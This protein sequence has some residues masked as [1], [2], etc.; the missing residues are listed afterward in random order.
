MS[1]S[2][3]ATFNLASLSNF[4]SRLVWVWSSFSV[5]MAA[6]LPKVEPSNSDFDVRFKT[7]IHGLVNIPQTVGP[8]A[9]SSKV[10]FQQHVHVFRALAI[11]LIVCTHVVPSLDWSG[12]PVLGRFIDALANQSSI[13]FFFIA[14]YLFQHLSGKFQYKTYLLQKL[15]TVILPYLILSTPALYIFT[16]LV[17]REGVWPWFY[18]LPRWKQIILF[19]VTGNH[20]APLWFVPSI[21]LL[22][23]AAPLL[24]AID[25]KAPRL[26][27]LILPLWIL[28]M[29]IGRGYFVKPFGPAIYLFPIYLLGMAFSRNRARAEWLVTKAWLPIA[30]LTL[31]GICGHALNWTVPPHYLMMS[32]APA[33][34]LAT[35]ALHKW[36]HIFGKSLDYIAQI[37]FGIFFIHAYFIGAI[38]IATVYFIHHRLYRGWGSEDLPGSLPVFLAYTL[39]VALLSIGTL[40]IAQK[41]FGEKSRMI[42]GA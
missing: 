41:V 24:L 19:L 40:W 1:R 13:F 8:Q 6:P 32:K 23:L 26:Y 29:Y 34:L 37:S 36:H 42:I 5:R 39:T 11:I 22:Y 31:I 30:A 18:D 35:I 25:R 38:K 3:T 10:P 15:K 7:P 16:F 28:S 9:V 14:G 17:P 12:H 2:N 20:L 33:A 4:Y 27:W 21:S